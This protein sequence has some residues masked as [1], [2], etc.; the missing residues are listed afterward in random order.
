MAILVRLCYHLVVLFD[1]EFCCCCFS[2][3]NEFLL[4]GP[5]LF[6]PRTE[7]FAQVCNVVLFRN[8][9]TTIWCEVTASLGAAAG[10]SF[11]AAS[12]PIGTSTSSSGRAL[13]EVQ[14]SETKNGGLFPI[15]GQRCRT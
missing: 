9:R 7:D 4:S 3:S 14:E 6:L 8:N 13:P 1:R 2:F 12:V 10:R 11:T 5:C 15:A